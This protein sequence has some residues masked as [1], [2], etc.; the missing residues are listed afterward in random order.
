[1]QRE[2]MLLFSRKASGAENTLSAEHAAQAR[3]IETALLRALAETGQQ[4][5]A[6]SAGI[7]DTRI[8][9]W[10]NGAADGGGLQLPEVAAVLAAMGVAVVEAA[11]TDLVTITR[12]EFEALRTLAAKGLA[13]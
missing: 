3:M 12:S 2:D 5:V 7:S 10:K 6:R 4:V 8:S 13:A 1:M 11:P 9:R